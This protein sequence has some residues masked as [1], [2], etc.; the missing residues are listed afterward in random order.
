M[1]FRTGIADPN[2]YDGIEYGKV[3]LWGWDHYHASNYGYYLHALMD[4]AVITGKDP[5]ILG[6]KEK[7]ATDLGISP[8]QAAALQTI[9]Y[10][11]TRG[12]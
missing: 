5:R 2:P 6:E 11:M 12:E 7:S 3:D 9:A 1:A 4:F 10:D 8:K